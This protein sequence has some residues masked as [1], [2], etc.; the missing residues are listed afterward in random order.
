M[1]R[2]RLLAITLLAL[3]AIS[4][5]EAKRVEGDLHQDVLNTIAA[6]KKKDP[7]MKKF[8]DGAVGY[9][10]F[11][12]VGKGAVGIGGAAG[13]GELI[14]GGKAIGKTKLSQITVG[15][16]LG[17]QSYSEIIFFQKSKPLDE[18]KKGDLTFAAQTSAVALASGAS[19]DAAYKN[20][21][22]VFTQE[23]G[24]AMFEASVGGQK[25]SFDPY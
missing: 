15:L 1:Y 3:P 7:G 6:Y 23:N 20:G 5:P 17:G 19:A 13:S 11:P 12:S 10:V 21:V 14:V 22:V 18:F 8:F 4:A 9:A 24:G 25:F 2:T 16:Q